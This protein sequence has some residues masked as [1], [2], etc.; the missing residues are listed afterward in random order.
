MSAKSMTETAVPICRRGCAIM[1]E[2]TTI[3]SI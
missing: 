2:V 1:L 3:S